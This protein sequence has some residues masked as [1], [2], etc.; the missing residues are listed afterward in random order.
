MAAESKG[1]ASESSVEED[2][3]T[4]DGRRW[5]PRWFL[6][7][8]FLLCCSTCSC[9][10]PPPPSPPLSSSSSSSSSSGRRMGCRRPKRSQPKSRMCL[11][12]RVRF[13]RG[14][15]GFECNERVSASAVVALALPESARRSSRSLRSFLEEEWR[16]SRH[17][18]VRARRESDHENVSISFPRWR[19]SKDPEQTQPIPSTNSQRFHVTHTGNS[20]DPAWHDSLE[21]TPQTS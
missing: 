20:P 14:E 3:V 16:Q 2:M 13:R 6:L 21:T 19:W 15:P 4:V 12:K 9:P 18:D 1:A 7:F 8:F 10:S 11:G 5:P 17:E